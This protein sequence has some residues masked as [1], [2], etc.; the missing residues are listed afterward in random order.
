MPS[1]IK[2]SDLTTF[3]YVIKRTIV[4]TFKNSSDTEYVKNLAEYIKKQIYEKSNNILML[5]IIETIGMKFSKELP[6]YAIDLASSME[7][8]YCDIHRYSHYLPNPT[9]ELLEKQIMMT[10]CI[11]ELNS[12]YGK[13]EKCAKCLQQYI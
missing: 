2:W 11:P 4:N 10:L 7:L 1:F 5:S 6:G 8:I 13:D 9:K 12:R 3:V